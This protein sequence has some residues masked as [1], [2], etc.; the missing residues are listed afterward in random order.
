MQLHFLN[1]DLD[2]N[3]D[4]V[5]VYDGI[6]TT[7]QLLHTVSGTSR[8]SDVVSTGNIVFVSFITDSSITEDG[9]KV[10][11]STIRGTLQ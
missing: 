9:F 8:P 1:F 4:K 5:S 11:Y 3:N 6:D 10:A 2:T 7:A